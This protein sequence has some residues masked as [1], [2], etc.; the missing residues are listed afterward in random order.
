[1]NF[2]VALIQAACMSCCGVPSSRGVGWV[3]ENLVLKK[4]SKVINQNCGP[5]PMSSELRERVPPTGASY[6]IH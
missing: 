2:S 3:P 1:M 5:L 6:S 4:L